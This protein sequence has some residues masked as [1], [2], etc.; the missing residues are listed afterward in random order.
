MKKSIK[1]FGAMLMATVMAASLVT[2][3]GSS[4]GPEVAGA[5]KG[6][7]NIK[8][9]VS[10]WSS[11]DVLGSQCKKIVDK[12]AKA[13]GTKLLRDNASELVQ[14]GETSI[15]ELVRATYTV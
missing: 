5:K 13:N 7:G 10:I 9:G 1:R 6:D 14:A 2:G 8:I 15:D 4:A 3:C 11:T 12:A